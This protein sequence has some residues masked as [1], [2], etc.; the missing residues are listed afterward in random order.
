MLGQIA[1]ISLGLRLP[2]PFFVIR[3]PE[4][5]C[6]DEE[7]ATDWG[8]GG[9]ALR[10]RPGQREVGGEFLA[11]I[12]EPCEKIC[13]LQV[14]PDSV[15]FDC[16]TEC[17]ESDA[18]PIFQ[19]SDVS[20]ARGICFGRGEMSDEAVFAEEISGGVLDVAPPEPELLIVKTL[21]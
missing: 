9:R 12:E 2:D 20:P 11:G 21:Q 3:N 6:L 5:K 13:P 18:V 16:R 14:E 8:Y 10:E 19:I 7:R 1:P 4:K 17:P 15:P